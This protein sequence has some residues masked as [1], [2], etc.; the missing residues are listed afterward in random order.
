MI[1]SEKTIAGLLFVATR[2]DGTVQSYELEPDRNLFIGSS[3]NCGFRLNGS[4][5]SSIHCHIT[6]ADGKVFIKDWMSSRGTKVNGQSVIDTTELSVGDVIQVGSYQV[7]FSIREG[8]K[9]PGSGEA[10]RIPRQTDQVEELYE[11]V[12]Q[13]NPEA[14][15][16]DTAAQDDNCIPHELKPLED[17]DPFFDFGFDCEADQLYD[18]ETV[19]L[20]RAEIDE[21][22]SAL[23][24]RNAEA[25]HLQE[26]LTEPHELKDVG[27]VEDEKLLHRLEELIEEA[28]RSDERASLLE[29]MLHAAEDANRLEQEERRQLEAWVG[30]IESR[31]GRREEEHAAEVDA[32]RQRLLEAD[33]L[34]QQLQQKLKTA[35]QTRN[36]TK[37]YDETLEELQKNKRDLQQQVEQLLKERTT[38]LQRVEQ[39][40]TEQEQALREERV[41]LAKEQAQL[42]RMRYELSTK[43]A[44][45][46][47]AP[48]AV[49]G[50][51]TETAT[52]IRVLREHLREIHE[53]EMSEEKDASLTTRLSRLWRR[54]ES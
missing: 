1:A 52:R 14:S 24:Q 3:A 20:L 2:Q 45:A 5:L 50:V 41:A 47:H 13:G 43:L 4:D 48:K 28:N 42:A 7:S 26:S 27:Q 10:S 49:G 31:I 30:D 15:G 6:Q 19:E 36:A 12:H 32:L 37:Q 33:E 44:E 16:E 54:L 9:L 22:R 38:L 46:E 18:G 40:S 23:A 39:L 51:D 34:Q 8:R 29:E 21:L 25:E 53:E 11:E 35:A 17:D